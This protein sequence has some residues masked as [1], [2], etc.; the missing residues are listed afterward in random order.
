MRRVLLVSLVC[1][2]AIPASAAAEH[3]SK[4]SSTVQPAPQ[5]A[6]PA[7][8]ASPGRIPLSDQGPDSEAQ[9][10]SQADKDQQ[11]AALVIGCALLPVALFGLWK[12]LSPS[13]RGGRRYKPYRYSSGPAD[14]RRMSR[15]NKR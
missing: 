4:P 12:L 2:L 11:Y 1:L 3:N 10:A 14:K 13:P 8:Q 15:R 7:P 5:P 9:K 6:Q